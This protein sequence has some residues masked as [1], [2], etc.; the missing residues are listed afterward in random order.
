[1]ELGF[2]F[3]FA[4]IQI[5]ALSKMSDCLWVQG[6]TCSLWNCADLLFWKMTSWHW[7]FPYNWNPCNPLLGAGVLIC[8]YPVMFVPKPKIPIKAT[9]KTWMWEAAAMA[10]SLFFF[11][12]TRMSA[13]EGMGCVCR[14]PR[15]V[16]A[17]DPKMLL[18][19]HVSNS[20]SGFALRA[21]GIFF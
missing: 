11:K 14:S 20:S 12:Q 13:S 16:C 2:E 17:L 10:F 4:C 18:L 8:S 7:A 19:H 3:C 15:G 9:G 5:Y 21:G 1:M 6:S